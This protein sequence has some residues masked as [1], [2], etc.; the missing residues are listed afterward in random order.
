MLGLIHGLLLLELVLGL[1]N[2]LLLLELVLGLIHGLL[3]L[4]LVLGL[5]HGLLLL[6]LWA[7]RLYKCT[8]D[9][10]AQ[11][12]KSVTR[13]VEVSHFQKSLSVEKATILI[14]EK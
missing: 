8:G 10:V 4:E 12:S 14:H 2:G 11:A 1:I 7:S 5:I 3:L 13:C 9:C 6:E